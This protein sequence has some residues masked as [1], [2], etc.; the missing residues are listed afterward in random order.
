MDNT[1]STLPSTAAESH[2]QSSISGPKEFRP[3]DDR[4]QLRDSNQQQKHELTHARHCCGRVSYNPSNQLCCAGRLRFKPPGQ[5]CCGSLT[6]NPKTQLCCRGT[7]K[8][9]TGSLNSCCGSVPY[10]RNIKSCCYGKLVPK[11]AG[12]PSSCCG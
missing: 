10:D 5:Y 7:V 9:K 8:T 3:C 6:Y 4:Y 1:N 12:Q 11:P 2:C